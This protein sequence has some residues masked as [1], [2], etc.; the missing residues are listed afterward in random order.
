MCF[1]KCVIVCVCVGVSVYGNVLTKH[2]RK[3]ISVVARAM[4]SPQNTF[5]KKCQRIWIRVPGVGTHTGTS[6][7]PEVSRSKLFTRCPEESPE[8]PLCG[9]SCGV[10]VSGRGAESDQDTASPYPPVMSHLPYLVR[11]DP[12]QSRPGMINSFL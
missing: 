4:A 8:P 7:S 5:Y 12:L 6:G 3:R 11:C 1:S 10:C 9:W 2:A